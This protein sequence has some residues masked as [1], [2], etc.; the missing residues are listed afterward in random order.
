MLKVVIFIKYWTRYNY[1]MFDFV[2]A[3]FVGNFLFGFVMMLLFWKIG[4]LIGVV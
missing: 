4:E 1:K 2:V 3:R